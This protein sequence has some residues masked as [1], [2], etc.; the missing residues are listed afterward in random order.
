MPERMRAHKCS[1]C[2]DGA[3]PAPLSSAWLVYHVCPRWTRA[4][5]SM[6]AGAL[7]T[8]ANG[9]CLV[10]ALLVSA[11][12]LDLHSTRYERGADIVVRLKLLAFLETHASDDFSHLQTFHDQ[13]VTTLASVVRKFAKCSVV[14]YVRD[15]R[16]WGRAPTGGTR[17]VALDICMLFVLVAMQHGRVTYVVRDA[18]TLRPI[19]SLGEMGARTAVQVLYQAPEGAT[20][21][22]HFLGFSPMTPVAIAEMLQE[23]DLMMPPVGKASPAHVAALVGG[24]DARVEEEG[25][26]GTGERS[27]RTSKTSKRHVQRGKAGPARE[28]RPCLQATVNS[29]E[30]RE[31]RRLE[32]GDPSHS[33]GDSISAQGSSLSAT[34]AVPYVA[35]VSTACPPEASCASAHAHTHAGEQVPVPPSEF[36]ASHSDQRGAPPSGQEALREHDV[37]V[38][39]LAAAMSQDEA[40]AAADS[41]SESCSAAQARDDIVDATLHTCAATLAAG[42]TSAGPPPPDA[43]PDNSTAPAPVSAETPLVTVNV[44]QLELYMLTKNRQLLARLLDASQRLFEND[45]GS[46]TVST[47]RVVDAT[48]DVQLTFF[49]QAA[50]FDRLRVGCVYYIPLERAQIK[51]ASRFNSARLAFEVTL[52]PDAK[53]REAV[54]ASASH[55]PP[56]AY[57]F[58]PISSLESVSIRTTADVLGVVVNV[59]PPSQYIRKAD[60]KP[61][62]KQSLELSDYSPSDDSPR[63][64]HAMLFLNDGDHLGLAVGTVVALRGTIEVWQGVTSLTVWPGAISCN[65]SLPETLPLVDRWRRNVQPVVSLHP[66]WSFI[67][68][69]TLPRKSVGAHVDVAVVVNAV[70]VRYRR[71]VEAASGASLTEGPLLSCLMARVVRW[72]RK[73]LSTNGRRTAVWERAM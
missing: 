70:H 42:G 25:S 46:G 23:S 47:L 7:A 72:R 29:D 36:A 28:V 37:E 65:P 58:V 53:L 71:Q 33:A 12:G 26:S 40:K 49:N 48:S 27:R 38:L 66:R 41:V 2:C 8:V 55:I 17:F 16:R 61:R 20:T 60:G 34:I 69:D 62:I 10:D 30:E 31:M 51:P 3:C 4:Q 52:G 54:A 6:P 39:R 50:L 19:I 45:R 68:L 5:R 64:I 35:G 22:G 24:G 9:N 21:V 43:A 57:R 73:P 44:N 32:N 13:R 1:R 67:T 56:H 14:Q 11:Q 63:S 18:L 15:K 59:A